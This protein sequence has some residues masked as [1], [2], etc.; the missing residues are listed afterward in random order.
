[1]FISLS[2][3]NAQNG[4][5]V[6]RFSPPNETLQSQVDRDRAE[7]QNVG[8]R[9]VHRP[10]SGS[11]C[12]ASKECEPN[13]SRNEGP[14]TTSSTG[15]PHNDHRAPF[16]FQE[17]AIKPESRQHSEWTLR[18]TLVIILESNL[19]AASQRPARS[20]L[21]PEQNMLYCG[22]A[23]ITCKRCIAS[24][25]ISQP[26]RERDLVCLENPT[27]AP[28]P[29]IAMANGAKLVAPTDILAC[30]VEVLQKHLDRA[31]DRPHPNQG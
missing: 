1:M 12:H 30:Q 10:V 13:D 21:P 15:N 14:S 2:I 29:K 18:R 8:T 23:A 25:A 31:I 27:E 4:S 19:R 22:T 24:R 16:V 11:A 28:P 20:D 7:R 17:A 26:T 6:R 9:S 3:A 5:I